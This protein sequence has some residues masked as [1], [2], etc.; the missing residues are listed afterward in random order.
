[1]SNESRILLEGEE[2]TLA[3]LLEQMHAVRRYYHL[4][5]P[6][7]PAPLF[8]HPEF[9]GAVR[10][11]VADQPR[12]RM[13]FIVPGAKEWRRQCPQFLQLSERLRSA[14]QLRVLPAEE[15]RERALF[16]RL[17]AVGDRA[18]VLEL[19]DLARFGGG[20]QHRHQSRARQLLT[21]FNE[22]W[23]KSGPDAELRRLMI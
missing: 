1:M 11:R 22:V 2:Q 17:F 20:Y 5:T 8:N 4:Y 9:L 19:S 14:M 16:Q 6:T 18:S 10:S 7:L 12:I 21:F 3:M 23:E 13:Q 15:P